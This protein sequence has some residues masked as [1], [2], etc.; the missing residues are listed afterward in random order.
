MGYGGFK[1]GIAPCEVKGDDWHFVPLHT[2]KV[3]EAK[4]DFKAGALTKDG[5]K[6]DL[7]AGDV[8]KA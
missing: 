3:G 1:Y 4:G 8:K 6:G 2:M 7:K 5:V